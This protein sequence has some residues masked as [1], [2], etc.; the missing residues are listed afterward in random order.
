MNLATLNLILTN[1]D[2]GIKLNL[3]YIEFFLYLSFH[4]QIYCDYKTIFVDINLSNPYRV[5]LNILFQIN[6]STRKRR[7]LKIVEC[8]VLGRLMT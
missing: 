2:F 1:L 7:Q 4:N 5:H 3:G 6:K 8:L